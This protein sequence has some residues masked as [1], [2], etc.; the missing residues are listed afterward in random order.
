MRFLEFLDFGYR[1][2]KTET[3]KRH[4]S[5]NL[6]ERFSRMSILRGFHAGCSLSADSR[7][8]V[9]ASVGANAIPQGWHLPRLSLNP[10][11]TEVEKKGQLIRS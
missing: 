2:K 4:F 6:P 11:S 1:S 8:T 7:W 5:D 10:F 9:I 3:K